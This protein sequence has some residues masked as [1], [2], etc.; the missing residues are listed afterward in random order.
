MARV[1]SLGLAAL[2]GSLLLSA[3]GAT[4]ASAQS[5][6]LKL[7][8]THTRE[9]IEVVYKR[10]GSY[11]GSGLRDLNRFLRD[12]RRNEATKMDPELFDLLWEMQQEFGGK[13]IS[14]VSAYRSPATNSMLRRRSRGV[15]KNSQHMLGHAID[16]YIKGA[17]LAQLR[18]AGMRR[19]VGGVGY[20][21]TSG[22]PFV[23]MDTGRVR[24]WP[25]MSRSELVRIF[26]DGKT[27]H[28]PSDGKPLSGYAEA[29]RLEK[30]GKLTRLRGG[31][32]GGGGGG[33]IASLFGGG[34]GGGSSGES[35]P[36]S[37]RVTATRP[38]R[39]AAPAPAAP[40]PTEVASARV[41]PEPRPA[42]ESNDNQGGGFFRQLPSV[43]LGGLIGRSRNDA[44]DE[45]DETPS[46]QPVEQ[47][48]AP[49]TAVATEAPTTPS[50]PVPTPPTAPTP[51]AAVETEDDKPIVVAA[52]PPQRPVRPNRAPSDAPSTALGYARDE[53]PDGNDGSPLTA[54]AA[55]IPRPSQVAAAAASGRA[56]NPPAA[57]RPEPQIGFR[58]AGPVP[59]ALTGDA[60][61]ALI[62][63]VM[64]ASP[65][66][67]GNLTNV[68][69]QDF[70]TLVAPDRRAAAD[71]GVLMAPGF[72]GSA[73][74]I[75]EG[76]TDWLDTDRFT[77]TRV[78][79]FASP[80]S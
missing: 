70:A 69:G 62:S 75:A 79:V 67:I 51:P 49:L 50:A 60:V 77:G 12:W 66:L 17:N 20:Y 43:S 45:D 33:L 34:G 40:R 63:P 8:F 11:V 71:D 4:E 76:G 54:A 9:S 2:L 30:E 57:P 31:G 53:A 55:I 16:F 42:R 47:P 64:G 26:P 52:L 73:K 7:Y 28:I 74:T 18:A 78:T 29:E 5:R 44:D 41:A 35:G 72:L 39:E 19:Q 22:S 37:G 80:R 15:A 68:S 21:P 32:D 59:A 27:L 3:G 36:Q 23:H 25:R 48:S 13:T 56:A 46:V 24:A 6:T 14:I 10:N 38:Q 61:D 58:D 65:E 1:R